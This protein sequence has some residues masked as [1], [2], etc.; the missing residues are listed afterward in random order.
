MS[1]REWLAFYCIGILL[2]PGCATRQVNLGARPESSEET[3]HRQ[4]FASEPQLRAVFGSS[5]QSLLAQGLLPSE[6]EVESFLARAQ[7]LLISGRPTEAILLLSRL[8]EQG[9]NSREILLALARA[10]IQSGNLPLAESYVKQ[11]AELHGKDVETTLI[12][13]EIQFTKGEIY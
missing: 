5:H 13:G 7:Q 8:E 10:W 1:I 9:E 11:S 3:R 2:L 4:A 12:L 6:E